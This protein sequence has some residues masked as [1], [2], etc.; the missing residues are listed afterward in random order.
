MTLRSTACE[1]AA[2][3]V[4]SNRSAVHHPPVANI[5]HSERLSNTLNVMDR[6][7]LENVPASLGYITD[8]LSVPECTLF[9]CIQLAPSGTPFAPLISP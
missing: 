6:V 1:A 5:I 9:W 3:I 8:A 7:P 2:E 4:V